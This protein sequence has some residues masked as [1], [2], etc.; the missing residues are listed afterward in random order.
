[1]R[2]A[3]SAI[4]AAAGVPSAPLRWRAVAAYPVLSTVVLVFALIGMT[5]LV[6]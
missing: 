3:K 6:S 5:G 1:M 2:E 4:R